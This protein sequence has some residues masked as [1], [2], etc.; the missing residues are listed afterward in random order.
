MRFIPLLAS[1]IAWF[2]IFFVVTTVTGSWVAGFAAATGVDVLFLFVKSQGFSSLPER[3]RS[4]DLLDERPLLDK[5][6]PQD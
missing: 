4:S 6:P 2:A 3:I 1:A 5:R